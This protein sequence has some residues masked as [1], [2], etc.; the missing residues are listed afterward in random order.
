MR[1]VFVL[2]TALVVP[3]LCLR[4]LLFHDI[5][6]CGQLEARLRDAPSYFQRFEQGYW[7]SLVRFSKKAREDP[8]PGYDPLLGWRGRGLAADTY[9]HPQEEWLGDRRPVLLYGDS[10]AQC[11]TPEKDCFQGLLARSELNRTH[12]LLNYG[13]GG[14]GIDQTYLLLRASLDRF[15]ERDPI[16]VVSVMV[17]DARRS[18]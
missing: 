13:L 15:A 6:G 14:Y 8:I 9:A 7:T 5:P 2:L 10:F 1:A 12:G 11:T 18:R 4:A 17:D 16:V 3:E